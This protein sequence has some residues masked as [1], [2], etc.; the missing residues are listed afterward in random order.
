MSRIAALNT[1]I[2]ISSSIASAHLTADGK[3]SAMSGGSGAGWPYASA[4]APL[5]AGSKPSF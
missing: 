1:F 5:P 3:R 2:L 4:G